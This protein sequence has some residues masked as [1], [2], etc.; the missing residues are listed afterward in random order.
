VLGTA[1]ALMIAPVTIRNYAVGDDLVLIS[2]H[3]GSNIYLGNHEDSNGYFVLPRSMPR[4]LID[5]PT[6]VRD[7]F[8][9]MAEEDIGREL[10]PS[11][12]SQ[13]WSAKGFE[14]I[15][16]HPVDWLKLAGQKLMRLV[17]EYESSDNQS[18]YFSKQ[19]SPVL[20]LPLFG[21][22]FVLPLALLGMILAFRQR[23]RLALL[24]LFVAAYSASLVLFF[25]TSR[26]RM[27]MVPY[28]IMFAAFAVRWLTERLREQRFAPF[29]KAAALLG[30]FI[31]VAFINIQGVSKEPQFIDYYNMA[32]KY[33]NK[34]RFEEAIDAYQQS[35]EI[36]RDYLS[37]H[38]N[39]ANAY[40]RSG[41]IEKA[42]EKW[43]DVLELAKRK[44]SEQHIQRA[45]R[46]LREIERLR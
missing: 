30:L 5:N 20:T 4:T 46:K 31:A 11:E 39:L 43:R 6:D 1:A 42:R 14:Y 37:S 3:T 9:K 17:N 40:Q 7:Y 18:Y 23:E 24:Y 22:G 38:N 12:V 45:K 29:L 25:V 33:L 36:R 28:L 2:S 10:K 27:L 19:Y 32:N 13:Y 16:S 8:K 44:G 15:S 26:Y 35:I 21:Y 34:G 41:Q